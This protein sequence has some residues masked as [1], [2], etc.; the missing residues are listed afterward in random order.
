MENWVRIRNLLYF[1]NNYH[2]Y[3]EQRTVLALSPTLPPSPAPCNVSLPVPIEVTA[4]IRSLISDAAPRVPAAMQS[5]PGDPGST[6]CH[7][8]PGEP[9]GKLA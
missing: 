4:R 2:E 7:A 1:I 5:R 8:C 9:V 3:L 6:L